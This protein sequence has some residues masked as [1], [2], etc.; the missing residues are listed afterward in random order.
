MSK[1]ASFELLVEM[2]DK[3]G[4]DK[5]IASLEAIVKANENAQAY[6]FGAPETIRKAEQLTRVIIAQNMSIARLKEYRKVY[7]PES[8]GVSQVDEA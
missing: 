2:C 1:T 3:V 5:G 7:R 8:V 6:Y 4:W